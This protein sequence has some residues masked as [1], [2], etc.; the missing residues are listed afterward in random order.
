MG[1]PR[2]TAHFCQ[3]FYDERREYYRPTTDTWT[4][5]YPANNGLCTPV[6]RLSA[7]RRYTQSIKG[8]INGIRASINCPHW[9]E[10]ESVTEPCTLYNKLFLIDK[11]FRD[12]KKP[13]IMEGERQG[14]CL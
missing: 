14:W 4:R 10:F 7:K 8:R 1:H 2:I 6:T 9:A 3:P 11:F 12:K 5:Q 13:S